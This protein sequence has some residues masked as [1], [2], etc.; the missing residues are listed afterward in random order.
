M[1][2]IE[3]ILKKYRKNMKNEEKVTKAAKLATNVTSAQEDAD[4]TATYKT[5]AEAAPSPAPES[6]SG[7]PEETV[8]EQPTEASVGAPEVP[9][10]EGAEEAPQLP[11]D[12]EAQLAE[13]ERRGYLRGRN[14]SIEQLM[15]A[16]GMYER[17][18]APQGEMPQA[19][20]PFLSR[21]KVSIWNL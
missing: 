14:E 8:P 1:R 6:V 2:N 4:K 17:L 15:Q 11:A 12:W 20:I 10:E 7:A 19:E 16:P 5:P 18:D 9:G 3:S 21:E 13:A